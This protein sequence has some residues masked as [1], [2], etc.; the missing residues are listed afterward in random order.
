LL[1]VGVA[2]LKFL[3]ARSREVVF[4]IFNH[5]ADQPVS[6]YWRGFDGELVPQL[7]HP[8]RKGENTVINSFPGHSFTVCWA[9]QPAV[10]TEEC[11]AFTV[12]EYEFNLFVNKPGDG[13]QVQISVL[14]TRKASEDVVGGA[15]QSCKS[16]DVDCLTNHI[17]EAI[18]INNT[19]P[20]LELANRKEHVTEPLRVAACADARRGTSE[21]VETRGFGHQGKGYKYRVLL[22]RPGAQIGVAED[23]VSEAE[24]RAMR[25]IGEGRLQMAVTSTAGGG[26]ELSSARRALAHMINPD[27]GDRDDAL[28]QLY[29]KAYAFANEQTGYGL[30]PWHQEGINLIKY[31]PGMEYV[32]HCDGNCAGRP[33]RRGGRVATM[34]FYC[35]S[36]PE[37]RSLV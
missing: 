1:L 33:L 24:C 18:W 36:D 29:E 22:D 23:F 12:G 7:K 27:L 17:T 28:T 35:G 10:E 3:L 31:E 11:A 20:T 26:T 21:P 16:T 30:S 19:K 25:D 2:L 6:L 5:D 8:L 34:I 13:N 14:D 15:F 37:R 9:G 32:P 4:K